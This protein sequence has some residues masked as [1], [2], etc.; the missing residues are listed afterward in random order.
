MCLNAISFEIIK[1]LEIC[2]IN[3][4]IFK[5]M[6]NNNSFEL[7]VTACDRFD[8]DDEEALRKTRFP[9]Y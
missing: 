6:D 5:K 4:F 3:L 2:I 7:T 1:I 9:A 8:T